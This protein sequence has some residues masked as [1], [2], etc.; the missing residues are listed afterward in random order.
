[1]VQRSRHSGTYQVANRRVVAWTLFV[2]GFGCAIYGFLFAGLEAYH[3]FR[4]AH[5]VDKWNLAVAAGFLVAGARLIQTG[6]VR[7]TMQTVRDA[8]TDVALALSDRRPGGQRRHDPPLDDDREDGA[9]DGD[10]GD[11]DASR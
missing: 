10:T 6:S 9:D 3:L 11:P 7:E 1:M 4:N 8:A 5:P 2:L